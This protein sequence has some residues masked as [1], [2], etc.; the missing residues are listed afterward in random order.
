MN[1]DERS[2]RL[3]ERILDDGPEEVRSAV[4]LILRGFENQET[5]I[6]ELREAIAALQKPAGLAS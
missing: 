4:Y 6:R 2:A 1:G 5:Q 3:V